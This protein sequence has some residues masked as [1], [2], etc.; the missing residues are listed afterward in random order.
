MK[1]PA[2]GEDL[3]P[4]KELR[5]N[6]AGWL[7]KLDETG[8]PVVVTQRGRAA[9]VLVR[10]QDLD[11]LDEQRELVQK[12]LRGLAESEAG[13]L[14]DD[15]DIWSEVDELI[16]EAEAHLEGQVDSGGPSRSA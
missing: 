5:A 16:T 13:D 14:M 12:V 11:E 3:V 7:K 6:L 8:R 9:A 15:D 4:V 1:R 2:L 10:P